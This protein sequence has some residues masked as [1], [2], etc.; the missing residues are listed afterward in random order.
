MSLRGRKFFDV[1]QHH[2]SSFLNSSRFRLPCPPY[3][4]PDYW[5]KVYKDM[6]L[7]QVDEWGGFDLLSGLL[8]FRYETILHRGDG[9]RDSQPGVVRESTFAE[10]MGIAQLSTPEAAIERYEADRSGGGNESVLLLGCGNSRL[11]E[12]V[13]M[14][15]FA[16]PVLQLDVS[17]KVVQLMTKR[18]RRYLEEASVTRM[19]FVVEDARD[20]TAL[21]PES[22]GG[23]V[24][25]KGLIDVLHLSSGVIPEDEGGLL[26]GDGEGAKGDHPIRQIVDSVHRVLAPSRPFVF[27]SRSDPDYILRRTLGT[28]RWE[29]SLQRQWK[30]IRVL[31]M[32]DLD[33]LLYRFVKAEEV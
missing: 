33:M 4:N 1:L 2:P 16:G 24:V 31:K 18:Y 12:Q 10:C 15:S 22:V 25:D 19:E 14:S 7:D 32:V 29:R 5:D 28:S 6:D 23:G 3:G 9:A 30:D 27:F 11:G 26:L 21:G 8:N 20:L 17:S 13:L